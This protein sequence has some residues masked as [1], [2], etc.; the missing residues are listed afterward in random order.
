MILYLA[1]SRGKEQ[2]SS[3]WKRQGTCGCPA[4]Q[5]TRFL[6]RRDVVLVLFSTMAPESPRILKKEVS[7]N[8]YNTVGAGE[9]AQ[10]L[11]AL[12]ALLKVLSSN[13][14]NHMVVHNHL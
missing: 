3:H 11:K 8:Y 12:A 7:K 2:I 13:P 14:S 10:W 1:P 5:N 9:M 6:Y 4:K